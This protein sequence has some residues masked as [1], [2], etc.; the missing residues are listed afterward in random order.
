MTYCNVWA[1]VL[2]KISTLYFE[3]YLFI[4]RLTKNVDYVLNITFVRKKAISLSPTINNI[5][6]LVSDILNISSITSYLGVNEPI[7][8]FRF[9]T[10]YY[11]LKIWFFFLVISNNIC[12]FKRLF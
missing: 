2:F 3:R 11:M 12:I 4:I 7:S 5:I 6:L 10:F 1:K 9:I 8:L